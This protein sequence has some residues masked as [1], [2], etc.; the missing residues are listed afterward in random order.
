VIRKRNV[1]DKNCKDNQNTRS[2]FNE[3]FFLNLAIYGI[4][5]KNTV[6]P[7]HT[8]DTNV[9]HAH[10]MLI[11]KATHSHKEY[12]ILIAFPLQQWLH[13]CA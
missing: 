12:V 10:C 3:H 11:P 8:I 9:A 1:L 13:E 6:D 7:G 5:W 4:I 2:V